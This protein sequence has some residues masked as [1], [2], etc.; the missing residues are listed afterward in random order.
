[1]RNDSIAQA[2]M[3]LAGIVLVAVGLLGFISNPIVGPTDALI[4]TGTVHNVVHLVTGLLALYV[5][6]GMRGAAQASATI[7]F[8]ILYVVIFVAVLVSPTLFGLFS[9]AANV[10]LHVIHAALAVVSLAVGYM[11]RNATAAPVVSGR[12]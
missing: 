3:A 6:F 2:W 1:M 10:Y 8:G 4:P 12:M 11:A 5:A 7:G 9:V